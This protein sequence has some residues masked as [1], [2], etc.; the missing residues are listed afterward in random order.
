MRDH[1]SITKWLLAAGLALLLSSAVLYQAAFAGQNQTLSTQGEVPVGHSQFPSLQGPF[2]EPQE[3]TKA[4]L[5]CHTDAAE[6]IMHTTHWTWEYVNETTG[7]TLGKKS[8]INNFCIDIN[9]NEPRCTSCH[10]GYGWKDSSFDFTVQ[11]NVDCLVCHDTTGEYKKFPTGAGL[12]VTETKEFP[13]GSGKMWNPPD[14][15]KVAQNI[16]VTSRQTCG[17]CHFYGGGGDEV[18]HGDLDSSLVDPSFELDVHMSAEGQN[19]TCTTCHMTDDHQIAGSRYSM[20]PEEWQGCE[21]CHGAA[22]HNL[23]SLNQ[24]TEK[25]AC[26]TCHIP[27]YA[28]GGIETKMSWDWSKAGEL[29]DGKPVVRKD[30]NGHVIYDGQKGEFVLEG[31]VV[32]EYVWFNGQVEYTLAGQKID[33][34]TT[35][36]INKFLGDKD[37]VN[38]K[39]WPVKKFEAVQPFDSVNNILAIPHLFGKDD[40]A[41][42]GNYDWNKAIAAGMEYSKL[43][44]S[45]EFDFVSS[46]MYWPI[47]HMV[48]PASEALTCLDCHT[49]EGG[50]L[51]FAALGY[52]AADASRL[53]LFPPAITI[54]E[55]GSPQN[56]PDTCTNCHAGEHEE[57]TS[58]THGTSGVGCVAC[59]K[60]EGEGEHPGNPFTIEKEAE[61][62]GSCHIAEY[63]DYTHSKHGELGIS[64]ASCHNPHN[65]QIRVADGNQTACESCHKTQTS[66]VRHSTHITAGLT[67]IDCHLNTDLNTGHT[68]SVESDTCLNCHSE[69]IHSAGIIAKAGLIGESTTEENF[70]TE[71]PGKEVPAG[72]VSLNYWLLLIGGLIGGVILH[73]LSSTRRLDPNNGS[74]A[75]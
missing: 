64:C 12:P 53:T 47:T 60:L 74:N 5:A 59:H 57:W 65:Q 45:G 70:S 40:S 28:R 18:K 36:Q 55:L 42:W 22:P 49:A 19:F 33:P 26:Q 50:R 15:A 1:Q 71:E 66:E 25:V 23:A 51:D 6:E 69:T 13:A 54:G 10:T 63:N 17:T 27:E 75:E 41:Y 72:G 52:N 14:L 20:D 8:L 34:S 67:C 7:Q 37:D 35:I 44:Y 61:T 58:S 4:C 3:V 48:A 16:G 29:A 43:P 39:I 73:W 11:E 62:C 2:E 68:F 56:A 9:S 24:H 21:N 31:N 32:P 30:E 46:V 38:A